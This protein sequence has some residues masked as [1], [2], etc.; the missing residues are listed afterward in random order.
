MSSLEIVVEVR[1]RNWP[2]ISF[3]HCLGVISNSRQEFKIVRRYDKVIGGRC[4]SISFEIPRGPVALFVG[5]ALIVADNSSID[6]CAESKLYINKEIDGR[7][8]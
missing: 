1:F 2:Y 7:E 3:C 5:A 8:E 6:I 4:L